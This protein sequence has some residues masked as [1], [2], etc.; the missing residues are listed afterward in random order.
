MGLL[1]A[2]EVQG[3]S[4][5]VTLPGTAHHPGLP[6]SAVRSRRCPQPLCFY[7]KARA[8]RGQSLSFKITENLRT[9]PLI[10]ASAARLAQS[11]ER[12]ALYLLVVGLSPT[13]GVFIFC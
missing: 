6:G 11:A 9:I 8:L 3:R 2:W 10:A 1:A 5:A 7:K 4:P 12:K 13:V